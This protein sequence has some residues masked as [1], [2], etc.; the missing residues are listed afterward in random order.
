MIVVDLDNS[1]VSTDTLWESILLIIKRNPLN[2]LR[3][4]L[5]LAEGREVLKERIASLVVPN[6]ALLPYNREVVD[7]L[8]QA[9]NAG[10]PIVLATAANRR[11]AD[12]VAQHLGLFD[13]VLASS[14][15]IN[16]KGREKLVAIKEIADGK[17][18]A[19]IGDSRADIPVWQEADKVV[20]VNPATSLAK[21]FQQ[22]NPL[23]INSGQK[24]R[25][26]IWIKALRVHQWAKNLLIFLPLIMAHRI[27]DL[28][29]LVHGVLA[30]IAFSFC[31]SS[32]YLLNDLLDLE[33]DRAHS[34][35]RFRPFAAGDLAIPHGLLAFV[36]FLSGGLAVG[37]YFLPKIFFLSLIAYLS[38]T[39]FYSFILKK[40]PV[41]DVFTL[42]GLYTFRIIAGAAAVSVPV[43]SWL[44]A[45]SMFFFL[46]LALMKRYTELI[47]ESPKMKKI[48]GRGYR[49]DDNVLVLAL[50]VA[51][52]YLSVLVYVLYVASEHVRNLYTQPAFLWLSVPLL[53]YWITRLW[54]ITHRGDMHQDPIVFT[55][56]DRVSLGV[57]V[58]V[59]GIFWLSA[60]SYGAGILNKLILMP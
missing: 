34:R 16:L 27:F 48:A 1:L 41:I 14:D 3:V 8:Q 31:A 29:L 23:L 40:L 21:K 43:S 54:L 39:T 59:A 13:H 12:A 33:S 15:G 36:I 18:F 57:A 47:S 17:P 52:G 24:N 46:S 9:K 42:A 20:M 19:Y 55:I 37:G 44:L 2:A 51:S 28:H 10:Q 32:V 50:G 53:L 7:Y 22:Q 60:G 38:L 11:I 5:W 56:K 25:I 6:A 35:K 26:F 49:A 58:L 4:I 30:F 45:F